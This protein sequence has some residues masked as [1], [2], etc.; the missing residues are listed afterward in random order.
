M[1]FWD[2]HY[3][4]K[5]AFERDLLIDFDLPEFDPDPEKKPLKPQREPERK[6]YKEWRND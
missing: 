4:D 2:D 1:T 3:E 5:E 6:P